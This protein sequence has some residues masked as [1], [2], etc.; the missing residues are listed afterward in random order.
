L[1]EAKSPAKEELQGCLTILYG[2]IEDR[3]G[4]VRK[5]AQD[6]VPGFMRHL[7][8]ESMRKAAEKLSAVSKN[9]VQPL[10]DKARADLPPPKAPPSKKSVSAGPARA[11]PPRE[12][13]ETRPA[14]A[15]GA[16][17]GSVPAKGAA[18]SRIGASAPTTSK[19]KD[20]DVDTSPPYQNNKLKNARFRD[21]AKLKLLKWNFAAPRQEFVDQL[22][23]QLV[24]ANFN[25]SLMTMMFHADFK[26]HLKALE[27]LMG[28]AETDVEALIA[29]L[30]LLLKWMTLRFFETNPS[31]N[32]KGLEYL[33]TVF[34]ILVDSEDGYNLH[35]IEAISFIPYLINKMGD[36]K[37]L[38]RAS[39]K[40]ILKLL[41]KMY[42]ASKL[43]TYVL[44]G[45]GTKNAK[46]RA[47]CLEELGCLIA[48]NG[49]GVAGAKPSEALKEMAKQIADR[50]N[51]VR[52]AALNAITE[53]YFQEGE[54][55]YKMIGTL[56][57]KDM[58]MLEERIKRATKTRQVISQV[59]QAA[60]P[61]PP[62]EQTNERAPPSRPKPGLRP[63]SA[64]SA[65]AAKDQGA[66]DQVRMR[67]QA[68]RA[69][70]GAPRPANRPM[71]GAFSLDLAAIEGRS[72]SER[73]SEMGP[74]LVEHD[75]KDIIDSEP[76]TLPYTRTAQHRERMDGGLS[77]DTRETGGNRL[78][79]NQEAHQAV[80]A[81]IAQVYSTDTQVS[82]TA[83]SQLDELMKDNEQVELLGPCIDHLFSMCCMQYRYVL[84]TKMKV[85]NANGKEVMRLLQYLTMVLMSLYGHRDL[86]KRA[87]T[88]VLHDLINVIVLILLE[89][90][91]ADLPEGGQL[92]RAL[93]V[94]TVKIVD[95]SDHNAVSGAL[96]KLLHECIGSS[97]LSGKY[98]VLV[99]KC[100]WKVIRGLPSWLDSMDVSLL[101]ADLHSF[102][103]SYP[104]SYWKQQSDDTPMRTVKTVIHTLVK[105]Q[106]EAILGCLGRIQDPQSSELVPY[107]RKL[108][109]S[110]VGEEAGSSGGQSQTAN[111][112]TGSSSGSA[113]EKK[114]MPRFTKSDHEALVEIFKK[115]GQK[116]LTKLGLQELFNFKQDNPHV[117]LE[118][119]LAQSSQYFRDYIERGLRK[120]E[121]EV[122][123]GS[124]GGGGG[125][126]GGS[127][128]IRA[129][130]SGIPAPRSTVLSD[131]TTV[132]GSQPQHLVYLE[133][134]KKLRAAGGL[135]EPADQENVEN[136]S[137]G[138]P[139]PHSTGYGSAIGSG[140]TQTRGTTGVTNQ[141]Y[142]SSENTD[143]NQ[144]E[145][146][147]TAAP[148]VDEIRK[149][150]AKIKAQAF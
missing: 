75:L 109:N 21:E 40:S 95:R 66:E 142:A 101:L 103:V 59:A 46:Q 24:T 137:S 10:L 65:G 35:D 76:V 7:G 33:N 132:S 12:P 55:L 14:T 18:K 124:S 25:K 58:A 90:G 73:L 93:N 77:P 88:V 41:C 84:Q 111:N 97:V 80:N 23:D 19:K 114:K 108:L 107:I 64:A 8:F 20:E 53:T 74:Q 99:M 125:G 83:L 78:L 134:L 104:G 126:G 47:E 135:S 139:A 57:D 145:N 102:L 26:Q 122:R 5:A 96:V 37:D 129:P 71:S 118:P 91:I 136:Y 110:G 39:C 72:G 92:V 87:A 86:V 89:P 62:V 79:A 3:S 128:G 141:R 82:I 63:P 29:N 1:P 6:A 27:M 117:D 32:M 30:D 140:Y 147:N 115:I 44:T 54:K 38:I 43:F 100:I 144:E 119:F 106:G 116:E 68:A 67:Y 61:P 48:S 133:R 130:Q 11:A 13:S 34:T 4:E 9:S 49:T 45:I 112:R 120:I 149:R 148:N 143:N 113:A 60:A 52:N 98:C 131:N 150:L 81:V 85:D 50:D 94:L 127:M 2:A 28:H 146:Q 105:N 138:I 56:P 16:R 22:K 51:S 69:A 123:S 17:K 70:S 42:P 15:G 31:V 121:E 36:P